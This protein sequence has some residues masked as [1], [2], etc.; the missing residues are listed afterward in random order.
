MPANPNW[1]RWIFSS[2]ATYLKEVAK[3]HDI[4]VIVEG[5]DERTATYMDATDRV[6]IRITGPFTREVS[7]NYYV[8]LVE[9]NVLISSR[10]DGPDKKNRYTFADI[11]GVFHEA[12]DAAI[13]VYRFG[14]GDQD[15]QSLIGCLSPQHGKRDALRVFHFGQVNS[16]DGI[17]QSMID[18]KY[19]MELFDSN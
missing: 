2:L 10:F 18:A 3:V 13:S 8:V 7:H 6:E 12:M 11:A 16:T 4:P 15:D 19:V 1:A 5:L 9:A 17:R 14:T